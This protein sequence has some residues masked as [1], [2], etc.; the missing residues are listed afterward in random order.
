M[1]SAGDGVERGLA[2]HDDQEALTSLLELKKQM[3]KKEW[4]ALRVQLQARYIDTSTI[5]DLF[6]TNPDPPLH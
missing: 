2:R 4:D 1:Y 3:D 6:T 5:P